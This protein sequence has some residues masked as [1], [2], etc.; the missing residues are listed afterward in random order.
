MNNLD[1]AGALMNTQ[2]GNPGQTT[3]VYGTASSDSA[4]GLVMVDLGGDTVSPDDDQSIECET[5]FKVYEGDEVIISLIGA[6]G[7]GKTPVVVGIVGRGDEQQEQIDT[8]IQQTEDLW[9]TST[10]LRNQI[11]Q[12]ANNLKIDI[13]ANTG[14][15]NDLNGQVTNIMNTFV[16]ADYIDGQ[17]R[18]SLIQTITNNVNNIVEHYDYEEIVK[19]I[20][21][22]DINTLKSF[23]TLINGEIRR[24]M[25]YDPA[26][27]TD[28]LGIAISQSI[29]FYDGDDPD[30][31]KRPEVIE[32]N[33]YYHIKSNQTFGFYTSYGWQFWV[34]GTKV[35]WFD[36]MDA[37]AAL[38]VASEVVDDGIQFDGS[39]EISQNSSGIGFRY[40]GS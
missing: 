20:V 31:L 9:D 27:G 40:I 32:G 24:G 19:G 30:P 37:K 23:A 28:V 25:I 6:D 18:S 36:S 21:G 13:E 1:M 2:Q 38:H 11:I 16:T 15:I 22:G 33:T 12:S 5:T 34:N 10:D 17:F 14:S 8:V 26:L 29:Q 35:G 7:S 3:T 39:W 4:E